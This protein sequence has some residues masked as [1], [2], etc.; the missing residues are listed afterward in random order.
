[1]ERKLTQILIGP[2]KP[3]PTEHEWGFNVHQGLQKTFL[4]YATQRAAQ[5]SR[6]AMLAAVNAEGLETLELEAGVERFIEEILLEKK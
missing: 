6:A 5:T 3:S 4:G 1:M 2:V